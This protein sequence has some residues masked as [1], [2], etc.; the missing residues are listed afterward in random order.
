MNAKG[1]LTS[2]GR[3]IFHQSSS[4]PWPR[5][6]QIKMADETEKSRLIAEFSGVTDVEAER[7]RF[8]LESAGWNL[9]VSNTF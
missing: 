8:Y 2:K 3:V 9:T 5:D 1:R 4:L 7:A 6:E